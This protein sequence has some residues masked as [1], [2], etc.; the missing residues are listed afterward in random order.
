MTRRVSLDSMDST[1][2]ISVLSSSLDADMSGLQN[3]ILK[4]SRAIE[5][6]IAGPSG[7]SEAALAVLKALFGLFKSEL[8]VNLSLR[9]RIVKDRAISQKVRAEIDT[10]FT[11]VRESGYESGTDF[12]EIVRILKAQ[13]AEVHQLKESIREERR[14]YTRAR[15]AVKRVRAELAVSEATIEE[16]RCQFAIGA[17]EKA[18]F[19]DQIRIVSEE[20]QN[21][22]ADL[23]NQIRELSASVAQHIGRRRQLKK[24][25]SAVKQQLAVA[26]CELSKSKAEMHEAVQNAVALQLD[27]SGKD[28]KLSELEHQFQQREGYWCSQIAALEQKLRRSKG[29]SDSAAALFRAD[30][31]AAND[32]ASE[33]ATFLE[34]AKGNCLI[35]KKKLARW[36][37]RSL[38]KRAKLIHSRTNKQS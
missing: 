15:T 32:R 7:D 19:A 13:R 18:E 25:V 6:F 9:Q 26:D 29:E 31:S 11:A 5:S 28:A 16:G 1:S 22:V 33:K 20:K 37:K 8:S 23:Q 27:I 10:F 30:L 12:T 17:K 35:S 24:E 2:E 34:N 36:R 21:A 38:A 4:R 14:R 3:E